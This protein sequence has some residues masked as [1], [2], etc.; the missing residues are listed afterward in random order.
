MLDAIIIDKHGNRRRA[1]PGEQLA[2]GETISVP[3]LLMD[4]L[5][6]HD[7]QDAAAVK[8]VDGLGNPAGFR[9]G[10]CYGNAAANATAVNDAATKAYAERAE[11]KRTAWQRKD[12]PDEDATRSSKQTELWHQR[13]RLARKATTEAMGGRDAAST[14]DQLRAVADQAW[15]DRNTRKANAWK[16]DRT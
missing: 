1:Q 3:M 9:R 11:R 16:Q 13:Q 10:F 15:A 6:D 8:V 12:Q 7:P 4:A 14:L 2:D 5:P